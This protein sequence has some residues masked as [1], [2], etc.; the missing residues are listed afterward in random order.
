MDT[1]GWFFDELAHL[2]REHLDAAY[3]AGYDRKAQSD[4]VAAEEVVVLRSLG[5]DGPTTLVDLG[6]G[7]GRSHSP[8]PLTA[9]G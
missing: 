3:A 6:A 5:L 1:K 2:G 9:A 8:L 4:A 7:T